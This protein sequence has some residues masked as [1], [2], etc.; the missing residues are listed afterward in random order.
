MAIEERIQDLR[1]GKGLSQ[2]Q[3]A[4]TLGV[5]RQAVSKWESGHSFPEIEKLIAMSELFGVTVD[6]ILKGETPFS[7]NDKRYSA[8]IIGSQAISAVAAMLF[9]V[10]IFSTFGRLGDGSYTMDIF[11]GL[12]IES[13]AVTLV[14]VGFFVAGGRVLSKLLWIANMLLTG[15]LPSLLFSLLLLRLTPTVIPAVTPALLVVFSV[16]YMV[17]CGALVYFTLLRKKS[18]TV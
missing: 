16:F 7:Q 4:E 6:Y 11:G 12:V 18:S 2:E 15:I 3:L 9:A 10:G 1:K 14:L 13:V 8:Q 5:S 17:I